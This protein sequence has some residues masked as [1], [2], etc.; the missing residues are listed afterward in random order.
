V[1][2]TGSL[3]FLGNPTC[4]YAVLFD[5]G[6]TEPSGLTTVAAR[7]PQSP[8]RRLPR[9]VISRLDH[10][11]S[12][13]AVYA[14]QCWLPT[15]HARLASAAGQALPEGLATLWVPSKGFRLCNSFTFAS[16]FPKFR[17]ARTYPLF[18]PHYATRETLGNMVGS[19]CGYTTSSLSGRHGARKKQ[20]RLH[21]HNPRRR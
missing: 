6:R 3:T 8:L 14:S 10:T 17:D 12:A 15:H 4:A 1:K 9:A 13:L 18:P 19:I 2:T 11:A 16:S 21:N 5:P 7:P 20:R